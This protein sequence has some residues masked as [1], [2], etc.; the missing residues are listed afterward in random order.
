[1][2]PTD[3]LNTLIG[4]HVKESQKKILYNDWNIV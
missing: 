4:L 1:M 2:I 3:F